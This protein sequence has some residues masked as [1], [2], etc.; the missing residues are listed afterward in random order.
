MTKLDN[1][2]TSVKAGLIELFDY[3]SHIFPDIIC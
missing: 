3:P 1:A 2:Q